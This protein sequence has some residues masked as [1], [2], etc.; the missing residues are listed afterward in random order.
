MVTRTSSVEAFEAF[1]ARPA[2]FDLIITDL[3]MPN[4]T[5]IQLAKKVKSIRTDIPIILCT[6]FSDSVTESNAAAAGISE[7]VMKPL[8]KEDT[9]KVIRKVLDNQMTK[10]GE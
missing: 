8:I 7:H 3:T 1:S 6:G 9:A 5:G 4:M 2:K 10:N